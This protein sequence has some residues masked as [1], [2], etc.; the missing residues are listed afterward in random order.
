M[1]NLHIEL[2]PIAIELVVRSVQEIVSFLLEPIYDPLELVREDI[3][4]FQIVFCQGIK[5]L[6]V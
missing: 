2:D 1:R 4:T 3:H 6:N 5:L